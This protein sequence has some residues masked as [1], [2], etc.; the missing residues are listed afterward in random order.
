MQENMLS[1]ETPRILLVRLSAVGDCLHALPVLAALRRRWPKAFLGWAI[2]SSGHALLRGHPMV[3]HFHVFPR[4]A[5]KRK[6]GTLLE[7]VKLLFAF[8]KELQRARYD[9]AVD[10]QGL[11]KSGLVAWWSG[12]RLRIGF[13]GAESRELNMLLVNKRVSVPHEAVHVVDKNLALLKG[14]GLEPPARPEWA[15]PDYAPESTAMETFLEPLKLGREDGRRPFAL[16][17]PG[18]T[19]FTK[20]WPPERFGQVAA[21]L[22]QR[23]RMP[24]VVTWAGTEEKAAAEVILKTA[25][26]PDAHLAPPTDLRQLAVLCAKASLFVGNDTGPLHMAVAAGTRSVAVFGATDPLRNGPFGREHLVQVGDPDCHPCWKKSCARGDLACLMRV[27][28][29]SV[30]ESCGRLLELHAEGRLT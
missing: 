16:V 26:S 12:A 5:F 13:R 8:R 14:L 28:P 24:V 17:N 10:L 9:A 11:L 30:L 3:D 19:W 6:E 18:A 20:R 1:N 2:E 15:L 21:G 4:R 25:A 23:H 27:T 7:R 22:I 29:E